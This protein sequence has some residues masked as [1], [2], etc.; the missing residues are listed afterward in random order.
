M[1]RF[2][3]ERECGKEVGWKERERFT[4]FTTEEGSHSCLGREVQLVGLGL[5]VHEDRTVDL[6]RLADQS[7]FEDQIKAIAS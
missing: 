4:V 1:A 7:K 6:N 5:S 3:A 2:T